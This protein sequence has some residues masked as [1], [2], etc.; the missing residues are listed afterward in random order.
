M[1]EGLIGAITSYLLFVAEI[2]PNFVAFLAGTMVHHLVA[3][4]VLQVEVIQPNHEF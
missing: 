1:L 4:L 3:G 2:Q